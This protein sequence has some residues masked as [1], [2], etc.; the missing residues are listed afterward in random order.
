MKTNIHFLSYLAQLFLEWKIFQTKPVENLETHTVC[1]MNFF[2]PGNHGVYEINWENIVERGRPQITLRCM[3][4]AC[5]MRQTTNTFSE[6]VTLTAFP[7]QQWLYERASML[8]Y[9][10][11]GCLCYEIRPLTSESIS[12]TQGT[13]K[14]QGVWYLLSIWFPY[15]QLQILE[16][17]CLLFWLI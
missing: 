4:I 2:S 17:S 5:W 11:I 16:G 10:Y 8:R 6:Y 14:L 12:W 9:T 15:L 3:P 7:P 13:V 1:L